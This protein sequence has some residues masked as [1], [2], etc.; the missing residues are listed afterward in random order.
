MSRTTSES[1]DKDTSPPPPT[2]SSLDPSSGSLLL[3]HR[4]ETP[5]VTY[6]DQNGRS[7]AIDEDVDDYHEPMIKDDSS[8]SPLPEIRLQTFFSK[9]DASF[10]DI[11]LTSDL[12][13]PTVPFLDAC[14]SI[15]P[16]FD[17]LHQM[18]FAPA[19]LDIA[20]NIRRIHQKYLISPKDYVSLQKMIV[21]EIQRRQ[22]HSATSATSA[23]LWL[24]RGLEFIHEIIQ[25]FLSTTDEMVT[26]VNAAYTKT[27]MDYHGY[28]LR[29][30]FAMAVKA[31]P[32]RTEFI[33]CFSLDDSHGGVSHPSFLTSLV[34]DM[35]DHDMALTTITRLLHDFLQQ[36]RLDS[37]VQV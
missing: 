31:V 25:G 9:M 4:G 20:S 15:L 8:S 19:R 7:D 11:H 28:V 24:N 26:I 30:A 34:H 2:N 37:P 22:Y 27:L 6:L 14:R 29:G 17:K 36:N 32:S 10:I 21:S 5:P 35:E 12:E 13:I 3:P 1:S 23:I 33:Q 16:I 18:A